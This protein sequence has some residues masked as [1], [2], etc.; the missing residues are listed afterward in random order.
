MKKLVLLPLLAIGIA[1]AAEPEVTKAVTMQ[2]LVQG[3]ATIQKGI[4]Y[5]NGDIVNQGV[6]AIKKHAKDI[7]AFD[8]QNEKT[9]SFKAKRF[10]ET[11]A[12]ALS[13]LADE[14]ETGFSRHD[15]NRV[16]DTYRRIQNQ[17]I[18]CHKIIRKW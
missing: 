18:N 17:C 14:I 15:K 1:T 9:S 11:E 8:I 12:K 3:L 10:A 2:G 5:N 7:K 16:L 4:M 13:K 6:D